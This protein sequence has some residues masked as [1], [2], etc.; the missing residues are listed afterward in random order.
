MKQK[1]YLK[2]NVKAEPLIWQWYAWSYL[3]PP[4]QSG[5]NIAERNLKIMK[6]YVQFPRIH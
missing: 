3:I 2:P 6:S 5:C 1:H 4:L